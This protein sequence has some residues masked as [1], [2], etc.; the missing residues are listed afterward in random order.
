MFF[1]LKFITDGSKFFVYFDEQECTSLTLMKGK[2]NNQHL[3]LHHLVFLNNCS[4]QLEVDKMASWQN[5]NLTKWQVDKMASWQ[6]DK[7]TKWQVDKMQVDR[8]KSWQNIYLT[9]WQVDEMTS[10]QNGKLTKW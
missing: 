4:G 7:L 6:N 3:K 1:R 10:W 8:I 2:T 5:G 9:K